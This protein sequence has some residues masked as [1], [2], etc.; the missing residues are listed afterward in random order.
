LQ[1]HHKEEA[2][3]YEEAI[4]KKENKLTRIDAKAVSTS[5][6]KTG[7]SSQRDKSGR[8]DMDY[9]INSMTPLFSCQASLL[10]KRGER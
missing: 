10:S 1:K 6:R 9:V 2:G 5:L 8:A 7:H 4:K 3:M